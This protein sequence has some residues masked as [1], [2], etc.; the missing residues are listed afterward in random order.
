MCDSTV[1]E[2]GCQRA[3]R[4]AWHDLS[5]L[6]TDEV[7]AFYTCTTLYRLRHPDASL[8]AARDLVAEWLDSTEYDP[9]HRA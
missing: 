9:S 6:G 3:V 4:R 2:P 5:R 8:R 1:C 7:E